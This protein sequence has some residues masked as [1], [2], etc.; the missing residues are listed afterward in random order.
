LD[1][2][3]RTQNLK[4]LKA[5]LLYKSNCI[6]GEGAYW[7]EGRRSFFWVDIEGRAVYELNWISKKIAQWPVP[8][9]VSLIIEGNKKKMLLALQGGLAWLDLVT[10]DVDWLLELEETIPGNRTNDG[11]CDAKGRLWIGTM[12]RGCKEGAGALYCIDKN[13]RIDKKQE[14][15]S[16]PNGI[17]W[18]PDNKRMYHVDTAS[19]QV[20]AYS[21]D[22]VTGNIVFEKTAIL[23]PP[24][25]GGPDGMCM[26]EEGML[27][28]AHWG[29]FGV[30]RWNPQNGELLEKLELSV[31]QVT[32]CAFGGNDLEYLLITTAKDGLSKE[33]LLKYA[34]SGHV[35]IAMPGVKGMRRHRFPLINSTTSI[36]ELY[37][38]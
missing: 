2:K 27:W 4:L 26:D 30:Y 20:N 10:G 16:I 18:S 38:K 25:L 13:L 29:G 34:D 15:L 32:S 22:L 21:F 3:P 33:D 7:H 31:P 11:A 24:G 9:R 37:A 8:G 17:V 19:R 36:P 6:L 35:Y 14:N 23:V 5:S 28:I 12:D 1:L